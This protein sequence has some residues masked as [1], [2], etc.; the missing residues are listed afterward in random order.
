[1]PR[2]AESS[3]PLREDIALRQLDFEQEQQPD[4]FAG[5]PFRAP[6]LEEAAPASLLSPA[7]WLAAGDS[8]DDSAA[9]PR[10]RLRVAIVS[11]EVGPGAGVPHYWHALARVMA[12]R[13]EV[14]VFTAKI[15]P[16]PLDG[17]ELHPVWAVLF[18]WF[19]SH[20]SFYVVVRARFM[21]ARLFRRPPFDLI[22]GIGALTPFADVATVHFVQARELDLQAN[23]LFPRERSRRGFAGLD[24]ELY[25]RT[26]G[27]LGRNFYRRSRNGV[28]AISQSVKQDLVL[29]EGALPESI[30]VVPNGVDVERFNPL[31][32]DRYRDETRAGLGL[33]E[34]HVM[35]LFVGNSWGRKGLCTAVAAI[36]GPDMTDVRLVIV[37]DGVADAFLQGLPQDV[38][39]RIVFAGK[40][41]ADVERFYAAADVFILPTLYEP[42]GLVILEALASGLP[43]IV[44]ALAGASEWLVDGVDALLLRDPSD[45]DEARVAL[46]R[47]LDQP[48]LAAALS[49]GARLKAIELQWDAVAERIIES[50]VRVPQTQAA[51]VPLTPEPRLIA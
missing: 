6:F 43:S 37:G 44:S 10:G 17:V 40:H 15:G 20:A 22:L 36:Q 28:L 12:R 32:R 45:G 38:I 1:M 25:S 30:V 50:F 34:R 14:H 3:I 4:T 24:Y 19:L 8:R 21:F 16:G 26:M 33:D 31:N 42:F 11:P 13:H 41:V 51:I 46:R 9:T 23:G 2:A 27:W 29:F 18:G 7:P 48:L 47:I 39:D 49:H 35:V 5:G